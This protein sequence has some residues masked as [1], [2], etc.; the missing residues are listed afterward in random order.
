MQMLCSSNVTTFLDFCVDLRTR[1]FTVKSTLWTTQC[2]S[3]N[4]YENLSQIVKHGIAG[5]GVD[6]VHFI[7]RIMYYH[8]FL[9]CV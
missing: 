6:N 8:F 4:V 5:N 7:Y 9:T 3:E 1:D 2:F